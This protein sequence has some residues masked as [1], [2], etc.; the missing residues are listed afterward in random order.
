M[1]EA[2]GTECLDAHEKTHATTFPVYSAFSCASTGSAC[3]TINGL[4]LCL[5]PHAMRRVSKHDKAGSCRFDN[6]S[7]RVF[8]CANFWE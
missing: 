6:F 1:N 5:K 2:L 3:R 4:V 8:S 7:N